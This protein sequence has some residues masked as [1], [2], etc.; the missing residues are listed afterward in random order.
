[1]SEFVSP[2]PPVG[3]ALDAE[4]P[5]EYLFKHG[6][7]GDHYL[8]VLVPQT[9][10]NGA[11]DLTDGKFVGTKAHTIF[12]AQMPYGWVKTGGDDDSS[13]TFEWANVTSDYSLRIQEYIDRWSAI[14]DRFP[15]FQCRIYGDL[16]TA[17]EIQRRHP[18]SD[19]PH[20]MRRSITKIRQTCTLMPGFT[21]A[22]TISTQVEANFFRDSFQDFFVPTEYKL[23]QPQS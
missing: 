9:T 21:Y 17:T 23:G 8:E 5:K 10:W 16:Y 19:M 22:G 3:E 12:I 11:I 14:R 13:W 7:E 15:Y 4:Y 2:W 6:Y 18:G 20:M 1:M